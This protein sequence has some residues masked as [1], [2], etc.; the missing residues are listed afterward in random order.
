[1]KKSTKRFVISTETKNNLG[2]KVRTSG[3]DLK[4]FN[5]N[6]LLLWMHKRPKGERKDEILPLGFWEDLQVNADGQLTGVPSFDE[7]DDFAMSIYNKVENG[8][9][10]MA[11]AGLSPLDWKEENG[12]N[13][14][15]KS[16][17]LEASL[18]DIGSNPDAL[19]VVLY[20]E[21]EQVITLS[22]D[23]LTKV[24][25]PKNLDMKKIELSPSVLPLLKLADG[26]TP[27]E[28][29]EAIQRIVTLANKQ[30][31]Q[32]NTLQTEKE[33]EVKLR[34][35][36]EGDL[37]KLKEDQEAA[38]KTA[39][40]D[41]AI[42]EERKITEDQRED[43]VQLSYEQ[44][45][46]ILDKMTP[47]P[48]AQSQFDQGSEKTKDKYVKLSWKELDKKGMLIALKNE[49][50]G[51]FKAKFQEEFGKEYQG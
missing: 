47:N 23:Y 15:D 4:Q 20:D 48:T 51:L 8:T 6:P 24:L 30:K 28:A 7:T 42:K 13:W 40:L 43:F 17:L 3:I 35:K 19:A 32:I 41:K 21:N 12:E 22:Q 9:L 45:K 38:Q 2:F 33:E 50:F 31:T 39:L 18:C 46:S 25:P 1:M 29:E 5:K 49:D 37:K 44:A 10:K 27:Q 11:S 26:A 34:E 16:V 14:L 36:A